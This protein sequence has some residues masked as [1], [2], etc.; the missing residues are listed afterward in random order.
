MKFSSRMLKYDCLFVIPILHKKFGNLKKWNGLS[1]LTLVVAVFGVIPTVDLT[2]FAQADNTTNS[3]SSEPL[4]SSHFLT[5]QNATTGFTLQYPSYFQ[6]FE[7]STS[8]S[9]AVYFVEP[10][11]GARF[12]VANFKIPQINLLHEPKN[13]IVATYL[14]GF[15]E[16]FQPFNATQSNLTTLAGNPANKTEI[17]YL[18]ADHPA[19]ITILS[20]LIGDKVYILSYAATN[21]N[22]ALFLPTAQQ[23]IKSF[24]VQPAAASTS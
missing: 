10:L 14:N 24:S 12:T 9:S 6:K 17:S 15:T 20:S 16:S 2:A 11:S 8:N 23:M 7:N 18:Y 3:T 21:D 19:T 5:Y 13:L 1:L 22:Y 4:S